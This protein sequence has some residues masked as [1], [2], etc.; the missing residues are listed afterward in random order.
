MTVKYIIR[1]NVTRE[2]KNHIV[3]KKSALFF[4]F[5]IFPVIIAF[6]VHRIYVSPAGNDLNEGT[7]EKPLASLT[8]ARDQVRKLRAGNLL[9]VTDTVYI[10][11][12]PGNY[13]MQEPLKLEPA[14]GGTARGPVVFTGDPDKRSVFTAASKQTNLKWSAKTCGAFLSL[15]Q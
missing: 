10:H 12:M 6:P 5:L 15:K 4:A 2:V 7:K 1:N 11:V 8:G 13:F 9:S 14:D 3:M